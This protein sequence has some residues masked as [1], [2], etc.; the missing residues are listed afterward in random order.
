[1][2]AADVEAKALELMAPCLGDDR[3]RAVIAAV[4]AIEEMSEAR[5]LIDLIAR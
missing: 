5:S 2:S 1:M 4:C 3:A